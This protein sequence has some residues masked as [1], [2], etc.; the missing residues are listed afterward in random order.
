MQTLDQPAHRI[1]DATAPLWLG[2]G[3]A[4]W[5]D[6]VRAVDP[7]A[8]HSAA[9]MIAAAG[10]DWR[11]EQ[12]PLEAVVEREYQ[13]LRL[14]VPRHVANVRSDTR[15]VLGVVGEG[16]EPLQ[17]RAAFAFCDAIT[18]S[19]RAHWIG[20]GATRGWRARA[21]ADATGPRD[22]DRWRGGRG[23]AAAPLFPQRP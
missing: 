9:G 18:D 4:A 5:G 20:A 23:R 6:V 3:P 21:R 17:N 14:P 10:L 2:S 11:V 22:Q 13:S 19:G 12:H 7:A 1:E 8:T 15:A 16:Y